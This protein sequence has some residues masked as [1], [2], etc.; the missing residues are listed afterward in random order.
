[1][2]REHKRRLILHCEILD[3]SRGERREE[4]GERIERRVI[5]ERM[6]RRGKAETRGEGEE[7]GEIEL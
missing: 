7:R 4:G 5:R 3:C 1:M 2:V 6:E